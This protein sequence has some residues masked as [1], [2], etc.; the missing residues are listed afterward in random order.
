MT[1][2]V[3]ASIALGAT[4]MASTATLLVALSV[5]PPAIMLMLWRGPQPATVAEV[6]YG[7]DR[8]D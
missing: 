1:L 7:P 6:L 2:V 4:V 8:R 5:V 3:V